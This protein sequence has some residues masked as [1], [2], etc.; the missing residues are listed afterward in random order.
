MTFVFVQNTQ[1]HM[2]RSIGIVQRTTDITGQS[3]PFSTFPTV[4][5][6]VKYTLKLNHETYI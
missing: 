2:T 4:Q 3:R 1:N 6:H 5:D